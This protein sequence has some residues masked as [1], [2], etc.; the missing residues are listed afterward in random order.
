MKHTL[1]LEYLRDIISPLL[2]SSE[3]VGFNFDKLA[4]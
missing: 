4:P 1:G 3:Q 2:W